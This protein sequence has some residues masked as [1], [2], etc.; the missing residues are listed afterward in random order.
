[1]VKRGNLRNHRL[2]AILNGSVELPVAPD[3]GTLIVI[4]SRK[5]EVFAPP[6]LGKVSVK[7]SA[8]PDWVPETPVTPVGAVMV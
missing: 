1:M 8:D 5:V 4:P 6:P 3:D 7:L 2:V